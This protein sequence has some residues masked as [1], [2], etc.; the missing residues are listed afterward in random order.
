MD[1]S[2]SMFALLTRHRV[3]ALG[4]LCALPSMS[5]A[6]PANESEQM[7]QHAGDG[8][9]LSVEDA[10]GSWRLTADDA[11]ADC[12]IALSPFSSGK[13]YGVR[14]GGCSVPIFLTATN[15]RLV[16]G[17]IELVD[18]AG[19]V[20]VQFRRVNVDAFVSVDGTYHL[21]RAAIS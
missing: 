2:S 7:P 20:I 15:W 11:A 19:T 17:G 5:C 18:T 4:I 1:E 16:D 3:L 10:T 13:G 9:R 14:V 21:E 12:L 8:A 6:R